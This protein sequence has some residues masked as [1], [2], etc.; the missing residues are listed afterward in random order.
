M[1]FYEREI[2]DGGVEFFDHGASIK[3]QFNN[4]EVKVIALVLR[5][6]IK[7]LEKINDEALKK[8]S[9]EV[10]G[11]QDFFS[12]IKKIS[13]EKVMDYLEHRGKDKKDDAKHPF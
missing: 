5:E 10:K 3:I 12:E 6:R 8:H 11:L 4:S 1:T 7:Q 13:D 9:L 2:E